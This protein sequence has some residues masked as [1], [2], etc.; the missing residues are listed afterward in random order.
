M[1]G[2]HPRME[3][4]SSRRPA[5]SSISMVTPVTPVTRLICKDV[6]CNRDRICAGYTGYSRR[7]LGAVTGVTSD[8]RGPVTPIFQQYQSRNRCNRRNHQISAMWHLQRETS[9]P[10][11]VAEGGSRGDLG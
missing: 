2:A 9:S 6:S 10:M 8:V 7:Q 3:R 5:E 1:T 4:L 11:G